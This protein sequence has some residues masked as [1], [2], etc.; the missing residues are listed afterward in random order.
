RGLASCAAAVPALGLGRGAGYAGP[1]LLRDVEPLPL[2]AVVDRERADRDPAAYARRVR[3][4]A[5]GAHRPHPRSLVDGPHA[6]GPGG[7]AT[8]RDRRGNVRGAGG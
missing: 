7:G 3:R 8:D 5:A 6:V 1:V 4:R 2:D